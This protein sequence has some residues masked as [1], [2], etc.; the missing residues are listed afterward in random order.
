MQ[1]RVVKNGNV[2]SAVIIDRLGAQDEYVSRCE[3]L[4]YA[5]GDYVDKE[6]RRL[7]YSEQKD[8][9]IVVF[10]HLQDLHIR[11]N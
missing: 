7:D 10:S 2:I 1:I 9:P 4:D 3:V 8:M 11:A 6:G 5:G